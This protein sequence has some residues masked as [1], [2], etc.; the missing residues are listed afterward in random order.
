MGP[1]LA[2]EIRRGITATTMAHRKWL[3]RG[4]DLRKDILRKS[5]KRYRKYGRSKKCFKELVQLL[6]KD[7]FL[8]DNNKPPSS[9][10]GT[11]KELVKYWRKRRTLFS[12]VNSMP[13]YMTSE[14]WFSVTP[15]RIARFLAN[16]ISACLPN[17]KRILDVFSGG[18]GNSIQFANVF[19]R[20]YCLD[21]NLEHLYCSIKNGQSYGVS[22]KLWMCKGKWGERTA[23]KFRKLN[24]DCI[25][26][27]PPWGGPEY[28]KDEKYDL[29]KSLLPFGLYKLLKTF[30][31]VSDNIILFLPKNSNIDQLSETTKEVFGPE[32]KCKVLYI[33]EQGYLKGML[34]LWGSAFTNYQ[35]DTASDS[36]EE[37]GKELNESDKS[38]NANIYINYDIDG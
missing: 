11:Q 33:K 31:I 34:C 26:G 3:V 28:I 22:N 38:K 2:V 10:A 27:S 20:V 24:I 30:K 16:F 36:E 35:Q 8:V 6:L 29:E 17:A 5:S 1:G 21:S 25:F 12:K 9:K 32:A 18:G 4:S 19:D 7:E 13:I 37:E 14:L 15:E 23:K